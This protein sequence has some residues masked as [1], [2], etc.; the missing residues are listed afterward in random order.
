M[1]RNIKILISSSITGL[2]VFFYILISE[3]GMLRLSGKIIDYLIFFLFLTLSIG[4]SLSFINNRIEQKSRLKED[5]VIWF[6]IVLII[7]VII[8]FFIL[9]IFAKAFNLLYYSNIDFITFFSRNKNLSLKIA[10]LSVLLL[11]VYIISDYSIYSYNKY[12]NV[13]IHG[14]KLSADKLHLH[15][16]ALENQLKP[17]YLFNNLNTVVSLIY[18]DKQLAENYVRH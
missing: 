12:L 2:F 13:K 11:V 7:N 18:S 6:F 8:S 10:V 16:E 4:Y 9:M 15:F 5:F 1:N 17:H 14:E 3:T